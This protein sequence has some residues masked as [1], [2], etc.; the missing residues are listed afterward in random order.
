MEKWPYDTP[1]MEAMARR[2]ARR[3]EPAAARRAVRSTRA[4]ARAFRHAP[5]ELGLGYFLIGRAAK[6]N[7]F[8][9]RPKTVARKRRDDLKFGRLKTLRCHVTA[10]CFQSRPSTSHV[11]Y[12]H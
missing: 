7:A 3:Q 12:A 10:M 11:A 1:D 8:L 6:A 2:Q 5:Q 9:A 4:A